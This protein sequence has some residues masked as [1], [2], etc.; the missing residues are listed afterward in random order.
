VVA[1]FAG[2]TGGVLGAIVMAIIGDVI[3]AERRGG[4]RRRHDLVQHGRRGRRADRRD[5]GRALWLGLAVLLLVLLSLPDLVRR[6]A[7]AALADGALARLPLRQVLPNL[8][9][10]FERRHLMP[11]SCR[12]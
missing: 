12:W 4:H 5:A 7:R 6:G 2:L 1:R 10:L 11:S 8:L 3:P 9:A